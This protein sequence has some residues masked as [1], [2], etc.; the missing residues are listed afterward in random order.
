[1]PRITTRGPAEDSAAP[2]ARQRLDVWLWHA[3]CVRTRTAA[4]DFIR[5]GHVRVNGVRLTSPAHP[6]RPGDVLTLA[7]NAGVRLW[8]VTGFIERRGDAA[9]AAATYVEV[10]PTDAPGSP[11]R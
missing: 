4:A 8:R 9:A 11:S 7:L 10:G 2:P 3:R 5:A 6:V 1:M